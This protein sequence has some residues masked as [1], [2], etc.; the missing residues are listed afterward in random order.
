MFGRMMVDDWFK[1]LQKKHVGV[2][3]P[4]V[5]IEPLNEH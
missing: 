1:V 4:Q 5:R 2:E 3:L